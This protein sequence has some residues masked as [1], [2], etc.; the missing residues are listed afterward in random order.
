MWLCLQLSLQLF[1]DLLDSVIVDTASESH[2]IAKLGLDR[3]LEEEEEELKL[4]IQARAKIA[5]S[6]NS[7]EA[8]GKHIVDIFGQTHPTVANDVFDCMNCRRSISAGR[9]APH[10]EKCM[11]K[12]Y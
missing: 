6:S 5:D 12:V 8:N 2:R 3:N 7:G 1:G 9:F 4:S 10:L 11:G